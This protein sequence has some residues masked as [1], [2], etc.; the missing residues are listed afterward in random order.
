MAQKIVY[1]LTVY[2]T[3]DLDPE[4]DGPDANSDRDILRAVLRA[5]SIAKLDADGEVMGHEI[6]TVPEP[7]GR[8]S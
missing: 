6:N 8:Q 3:E 4:Y 1:T 7:K 5:L 2:I